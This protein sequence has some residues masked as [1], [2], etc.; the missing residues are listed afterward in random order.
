MVRPGASTASTVGP[1]TR[2][3]D[4]HGSGYKDEEPLHA[5]GR[6]L[7]E[8]LSAKCLFVK[9][10]NDVIRGDLDHFVPCG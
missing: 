10:L 1:S 7:Q 3:A 6:G 2:Y 8:S 4:G 5:C 9:S